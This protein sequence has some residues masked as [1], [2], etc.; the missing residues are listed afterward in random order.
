MVIKESFVENMTF[1]EDE[2]DRLNQEK[3][4][5]GTENSKRKEQ[6]QKIIQL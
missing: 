3:G 6:K 1:E 5:P 2:T 4:I